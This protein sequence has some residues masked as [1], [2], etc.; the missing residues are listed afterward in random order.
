MFGDAGFALCALLADDAKELSYA[1]RLHIQLSEIM[2]SHLC[3]EHYNPSLFY[4]QHF[5]VRHQARAQPR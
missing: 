4:L 1:A 5:K 3:P 2:H